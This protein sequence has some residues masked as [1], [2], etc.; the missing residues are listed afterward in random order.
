M[1][2]RER[3]VP[4]SRLLRFAD[5]EELI[6]VNIIQCLMNARRPG[7]VHACYGCRS[8]AEMQPLVAGGKIASG[9]GRESSLSVHTHPSAE[10]IAIAARATQRNREPMLLPATVEQHQRLATK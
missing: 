7:D 5:F 6:G 3:R 9:G 8:Q 1:Q 10:A 2:T 4:E